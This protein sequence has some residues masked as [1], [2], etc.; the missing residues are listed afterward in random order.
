[1]AR[2]PGA[3]RR[4]CKRAVC[5]QSPP[6]LAITLSWRPTWEPRPAAVRKP[7]RQIRAGLLSPGRVSD[8]QIKTAWNSLGRGTASRWR[9]DSQAGTRCGRRRGAVVGVQ[10]SSEPAG[11]GTKTCWEAQVG[12][13]ATIAGP[14]TLA[15]PHRPWQ[16]GGA[17]GMMESRGWR[18][19]LLF[20]LE[21]PS[22][23]AYPG[24][25]FKPQFSPTWPSSTSLLP[26]ATEHDRYEVA[27]QEASIR[28]AADRCR[29]AAASDAAPPSSMA[30]SCYQRPGVLGRQSPAATSTMP[31]A[32]ILIR[33]RQMAGLH[34]HRLTSVL[35][36]AVH[37]KWD[38]SGGPGL[39]RTGHAAT[40]VF[41][42]FRK[43]SAPSRGGVS[44][45]W[46]A[47]CRGVAHSKTAIARSCFWGWAWSRT[48]RFMCA[49]RRHPSPG[50]RC[51]VRSP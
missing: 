47:P 13:E 33:N 30:A 44:G 48:L 29:K 6:G 28:R 11:P 8:F 19:L 2:D 38:V 39:T 5:A 3:G 25:L 26:S 20:L 49:E 31:G 45:A 9:V 37:W 7:T 16:I 43:P 10:A 46:G 34:A 23:L 40:V 41:P 14:R 1:M 36:G 4:P 27:R 15:A 12:L 18:F 42:I 35:L 21:P 32:G 17:D 50:A 51:H 24:P 22:I